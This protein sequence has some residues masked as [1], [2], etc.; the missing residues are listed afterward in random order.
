MSDSYAVQITQNK[1]K[2]NTL[3]NF[4]KEFEKNT[5]QLWDGLTNSLNINQVMGN[6]GYDNDHVMKV[7]SEID[8][9]SIDLAD[10]KSTIFV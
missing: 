2:R 4:A 3:K 9:A 10:L 6:I 5:K 8:K 7:Y 1:E